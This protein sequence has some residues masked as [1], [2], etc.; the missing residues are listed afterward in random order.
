[1][2]L[3]LQECSYEFHE[4]TLELS[5]STHK[6]Q[7]CSRKHQINV[8]SELLEIGELTHWQKAFPE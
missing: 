4:E 6:E 8:P 1:M 2:V 7:S 3:I 5:V